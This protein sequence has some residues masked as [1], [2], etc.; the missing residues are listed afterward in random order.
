MNRG[1]R[2]SKSFLRGFTLIELLVVISI[3]AL[4]MS[5]LMPALNKAKKHAQA[6]LCKENLHQ[7]AIIWKFFVDECENEDWGKKKGFFQNRDAS[8]HWPAIIWKYHWKGED[9]KTLC[10][11]LLCP[12]AKKTVEQG[13][14]NPYM[15][16]GIYP[17][18]LDDWVDYGWPA[19]LPAIS[20]YTINL[21]ASN[22]NKSQKGVQDGFWKTPYTAGSSYGPIMVCAQWAN[23]DPLPVDNPPEHENDLWTP[24]AEEIR[25]SC[26]KRHGDYVNALFMDWSVKRVGLK[27]L[28]EIWWHKQWPQD[29]AAATEPIWP[30][31]ME[32]M[33]RYATD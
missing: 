24:N 30:A 7:W 10:E 6:A 33:K 23:A 26:L 27:E 5:I 8:N 31:W 14:R 4:L 12:A 28:W 22:E 13:G 21:W 9:P 29:R 25:R 2:V 19:D 20:S 11:M 17:G 32:G 18:N 1:K 16:W 15:A 3:I